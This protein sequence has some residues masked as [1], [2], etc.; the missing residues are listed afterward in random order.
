[1]NQLD[2][3]TA[4]TKTHQKP[5]SK[6][7][8]IAALE[9]LYTDAEGCDAE[10]FSEMRSNLLLISGEHYNKKQSSYFRRIRESKE[11]NEQQKLRLTKNHIQKIHKSYVNNILSTAPGVGFMPKNEK[12][13]HDQKVSEMHHAVWQDGKEKYNLDE[14]TDDWADDFCGIGEVAVKIF[15]DPNGGQILGHRQQLDENGGLA[16]DEGGMPVLGEPVFEGEFVFENIHGFNLLRCPEAK[17]MRKSPYLISR[18]M[19]MKD[20]LTSRYPDLKSKIQESYD[21]TIVVFDG[22]KNGYRKAG[23]EVMVREFFFRPCAQY[24]LGQYFI[25]T[26]ECIL[27]KG[28]LPGG[29]FPIIFGAMEKVQTTPRGRSVIKVARPYQAEINRAASKIAE[30]HITLGDDKLLIQ[31]GTTVSA[32]MALPGIRSINFTGMT[33]TVMEGR[34]GAQY[35][36]Y[37][38]A[39]IAEMYQVL[40]VAEDSE[41]S[42]QGQVD[43]Y[44]ILFRTASQKKK[45]QRYIKRFERFLIEVA[46]TYIRLC[47]IHMDDNALVCAVGKKERVNIPE[48]KKSDDTA[49]DVKVDAQS[50]DVET[51]MGKQLVLNHMVQYAGSQLKP[52]DLGKLMREMPY[53]NFEGSF[54]D[55]TLDFDSANNIILA[56]DRGERPNGSM[57]D[58]LPYMV[59]RLVSRMRQADF[60]YLD[61][62]VQQNYQQMT[63]Q[64][65]HAISIQ[66]QQ[67][68]AAK[69]G[70]IPTGG[71]MVV[72]DIYV[73]DP[74]SPEKTR[75]ARLPYEALQWL[76]QRLETQG[77]GQQQ[78]ED[79]NQGA[80]AQMSQMMQSKQPPA[81]QG[82]DQG[83]QQVLPQQGMAHGAQPAP[84]AM[85]PR[86]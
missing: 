34:S 84:Q 40:N 54:G 63:Q 50:D 31:N 18:K 76:V 60:S 7:H 23:N 48:F 47:K 55:L 85:P 52:E 74:A 9:K 10:I 61:P 59:K 66:Q 1:M 81:M 39:Q 62:Q 22:V 25:T 69:D 5:E 77:S 17:V 68:Q 42:A 78:L 29:I 2:E 19:V 27:E 11:L 73:A 65:E 16:L 44:A 57:Y 64:Y 75:R 58:D 36:E 13:L 45:F 82:R 37:M 38:Q 49:Y 70:F 14:S 80:L 35:L 32:G 72:C 6:E 86:V 4:T 67:I 79:M 28:D 53:A 15:Y 21:S 46:K 56:L 71:Y 51:R 8:D 30:H 43:P 3:M 24:P 41:P 26:K 33:P 20:W 83:H 12:E